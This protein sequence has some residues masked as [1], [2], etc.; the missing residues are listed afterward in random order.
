MSYGD[1]GNHAKPAKI[2]TSRYL[3]ASE[4]ENISV[5]VIA[6]PVS[7]RLVMEIIP[8]LSVFIMVDSAHINDCTRMSMSRTTVRIRGCTHNEP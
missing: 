7:E 3:K 2:T 4:A 8:A 1:T 5:L 6:A